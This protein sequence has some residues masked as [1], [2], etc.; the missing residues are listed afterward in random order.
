MVSQSTIITESYVFLFP[1]LIEGFTGFFIEVALENK[2]YTSYTACL[3][4]IKVLTCLRGIARPLP[5]SPPFLSLSFFEGVNRFDLLLFFLEV[6]GVELGV[7]KSLRS[8]ELFCC[9]C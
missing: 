7:G 6:V 3:Y 4:N 8:F 9:C 5:K 1:F 2:R